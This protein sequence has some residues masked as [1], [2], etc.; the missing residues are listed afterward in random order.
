MYI[1]I[2]VIY[3]TPTTPQGGGGRTTSLYVIYIN[4]YDVNICKYIYII[5]IYIYYIYIRYIYI[6]MLYIC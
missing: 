4:T 5:Y 1:Y 3:H 2:Y 6:Y